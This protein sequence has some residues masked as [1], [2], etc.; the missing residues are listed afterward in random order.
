MLPRVEL[1]LCRGMSKVSTYVSRVFS[2]LLDQAV[3][4]ASRRRYKKDNMDKAPLISR[5][6]ILQSMVHSPYDLGFPGFRRSLQGLAWRQNWVL[7]HRD[8]LVDIT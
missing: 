7:A 2:S 5:V 1:T 3:L 4:M 6:L 8:E